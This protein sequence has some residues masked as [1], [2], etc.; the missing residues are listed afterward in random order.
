MMVQSS[1]HPLCIGISVLSSLVLLLHTL[2]LGT[3]GF[4]VPTTQTAGARLPVRL[5]TKTTPTTMTTTLGVMT[6]DDEVAAID[7]EDQFEEEEEEEDK[8]EKTPLQPIRRYRRNKKEPL[9]AIIGRP[10]VGKSALVNR[11]AGTQSGGAIVAD[12]SGITRDRTYRP[13]EFLGEPFQLVDTGGL[14]FDDDAGTLFAKQ[15]REQAMVA[16]EESAAVIMVCDGQVGLSNMDLAIAEF[17]R[18]EIS[19][20]LPIMVAVNKC[21]SENTGEAAAAEFW[22]LGLGQPYAVSALHGVGTADMLED[23]FDKIVE[24]KTAIAGFGTKV[25]MLKNAKSNLRSKEPLAGEDETD[26]RLRLKYGVGDA[27]EKAIQAYEDAMS[28]FDDEEKPV[29]GRGEYPSEWYLYTFLSVLVSVIDKD[30]N[31]SL[32]HTH[33]HTHTQNRTSRTVSHPFLFTLLFTNGRRKSM[34]RS[35]DG[36]M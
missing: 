4:T 3:D 19:K 11:I 34:C 15:I 31:L 16:I 10:N 6:F 5:S 26:V 35:L 36:P 25:K 8:D 22:Q 7:T 24:M 17:L 20:E 13:A 27:A 33:T 28:A 29:C 2:P 21:E 30:N 1:S 23:M 12:E 32:S 14:V 9:V 18:K